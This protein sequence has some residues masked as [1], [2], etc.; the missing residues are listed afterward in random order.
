[1]AIRDDIKALAAKYAAEL[2]AKVDERLAEMK[3][4]DT[5]HR[6]IELTRQ[7]RKDND[8]SEDDPKAPL[9]VATIL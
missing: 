3:V 7:G 8:K 5:S 4:D 2:K 6:L 1:M 9:P